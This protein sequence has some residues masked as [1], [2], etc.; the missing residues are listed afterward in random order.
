M[1]GAMLYV[2]AGKGHYTP[3]VALA[4]SFN[5][6]GHTVVVE[7]LFAVVGAPFWE[8]FCKYDWRFLLHHPHLEGIAHSG[9]DNRLSYHLIK[10]QGLS[11][12]HLQNLKSWY[13]RHKPDFIVSTN[14]IGGII[15]PSEFRKLGID[16]PI[17]QYAADVFDTPRS[18]VNN[19]LTKMYLPT[20]I[21]CHNAIRKGQPEDT[22]AL[23]PFPLQ[24][25]IK[26]T[27]R[28]NQSEARKKLGLK[29]KFTVLFALG[30][31]GIGTPDFLYKMVERGF[32]WQIV[33]IGGM[34]K[35][36]NAAFDKFCKEYPYVDFVR[37][38]FVN[39]VNEYLLAANIQIGKAGAN[40]LMESIYLHRP[41]I[42]SDL[43]YAAR[44]TKDFFAENEVG[45]CEGKVSKQISIVES[46]FNNSA[47]LEEMATR[48]ANLPVTFSSDKFRDQ[49]IKDTEEY[50]ST[51]T[52]NLPLS[53]QAQY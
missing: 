47:L 48:Y 43:L 2:N 19:E 24:S 3:A 23:C 10:W 7:D 33:A 38:G 53:H 21:G 37:P 41:C 26:N 11:K 50:Y 6:A 29:D 46:Y 31:E 12:T 39:N 25:Y 5:K 28:L 30:G 17:F 22:I 15:L 9:T 27:P 51:K 16:I 40:A 36:T 4:D 20:E 45:W 42:I 44:A 35:T 14:F 8:W 52:R 18:G 34:S 13:E 49:I 1:R 32:N